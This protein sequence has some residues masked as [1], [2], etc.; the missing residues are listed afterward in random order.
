MS[1]QSNKTPNYTQKKQ[2]NQDFLNRKYGKKCNH[3]YG[4]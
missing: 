2:E 4:K 1:E 3:L